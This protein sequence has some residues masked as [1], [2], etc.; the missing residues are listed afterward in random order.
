MYS[1]GVAIRVLD[2]RSPAARHCEGFKGKRNAVRPEVR[3]SLIEVLHL[4]HEL[5]CLA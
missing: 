5:G 3:D 4:K 1:D 2:D